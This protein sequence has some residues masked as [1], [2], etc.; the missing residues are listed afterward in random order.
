MLIGKES[1]YLNFHV[2]LENQCG[3]PLSMPIRNE[4][5]Y[6]HFHGF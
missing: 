4:S 2:F 6:L 5:G 3:Y 1:G